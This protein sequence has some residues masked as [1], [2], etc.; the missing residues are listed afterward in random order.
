[1]PNSPWSETSSS[2][3]LVPSSG[4][5]IEPGANVT[6]GHILTTIARQT[7]T[8]TAT[9]VTQVA[10]PGL[11][12]SLNAA[13]TDDVYNFFGSMSGAQTA[14]AV[15]TNC[16]IYMYLDGNMTG[17]VGSAMVTYPVLNGTVSNSCVMSLSGLSAG[18]HTIQFYM[19]PSLS[20][21]AFQFYVGSSVLCQR[22][23]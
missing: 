7:S 22:I 17:P 14:G 6:S 13:S 23:F 11:G 15:G 19:S 2:I 9:G 12:F 20:T 18:A 8:A 16:Y 5:V 3:S 1:M 21:S 10:I 4:K